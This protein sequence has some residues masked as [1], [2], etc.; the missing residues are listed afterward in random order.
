MNGE[1]RWDIMELLSIVTFGTFVSQGLLQKREKKI[2]QCQ[3]D[4]R[5]VGDK[6]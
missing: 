2:I 5:F 4:Y 1:Q 3:C 6:S